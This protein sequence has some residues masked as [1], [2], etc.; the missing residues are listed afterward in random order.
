MNM[1]QSLKLA[2]LL[3]PLLA[4]A[5]LAGVYCE[6]ELTTPTQTMKTVW[7]VSG[8]KG[9]METQGPA[10]AVVTIL[11]LDQSKMYHLVPQQKTYMEMP[12]LKLSPEEEA[13]VQV[14]VT[15]TAETKKI[16][17]YNCTRYDVTTKGTPNMPPEGMTMQWWMTTDA[18][19]V[20]EYAKFFQAQSSSQSSKAA[21]EMAKLKGFPMQQVMDSPMG[22]TTIT[23]TSVKK[24]D[25]PDSMFEVPADYT[26]TAMPA[27]PG[28][29]SS[30]AK[31]PVA[32]PAAGG[33]AQ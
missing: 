26:K 23:V 13:Q 8:V 32:P 3:V 10:G 14:T 17:D 9:R 33:A 4:T 12:I 18:D 28:M 5:A 1:K 20:D 6:Q 7:Y 27:M 31:P 22:K 29:P 30:G 16:A 25:V 15:K 2:V 11:R 19:V 24:Q 21:T